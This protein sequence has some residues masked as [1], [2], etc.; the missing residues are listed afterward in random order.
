MSGSP[1]VVRIP[2]P[3]WGPRFLVRAERSWPRW[4]YRPLLGLGTWVA[5]AGMPA[6]RRH[7]RDFL[8]LVRGRRAG[9]PEVWRHFLAFVDVLVLKLAIAQGRGHRCEVP[10]PHGAEFV[11]LLQSGQ[12]AL[13]GT[14][15]FGHS[16]LLGFEL[17]RF[18]RQVAMVRAR[19]SDLPD[20]ELL[21]RGFPGVSFIWSNDPAHLLFD[22]KAAIEAGHSLA[23][24]CD[25]LGFS[26]R[27]EPF[28]FLGA[29]R[30][31]P[32]TIYHLAVLFNRPVAFCLGIPASPATTTVHA[33]PLFR[34]DP[35]GSR[36][37]NLAAARIHF[38]AV[39]SDL[40]TRI[41]QHPTLWFN[42]LPLNPEV[43]ASAPSP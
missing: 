20:V 30:L 14:F 21:G 16:D 33:S 1:A 8:S 7:S 9:W 10:P 17:A 4:L 31:F 11:A 5:V 38:Q 40:E 15:H 29:R 25:R 28:R 19:A 3:A 22:L 13:F 41:R 32:F 23:L 12:P 36:E 18:G 42:F 43:P 37:E 26:A 27:N 39:L 35:R 24:Q 2:G 34:P 6:Q